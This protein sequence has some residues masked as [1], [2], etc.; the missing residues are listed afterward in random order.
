MLEL[1]KIFLIVRFFIQSSCNKSLKTKISC[2]FLCYFCLTH[3]RLECSRIRKTTLF[4]T[5]HRQAEEMQK[6]VSIELHEWSENMVN[7][8]NSNFLKVNSKFLLVTW[9]IWKQSVCSIIL[10]YSCTFYSLFLPFFVLE[11]FKFKYDRFFVRHSASISKFQWF[12]QL[13][14]WKWP[15]LTKNT[16]K[17]EKDP[18]L[19]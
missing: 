10:P 15:F 5:S 18:K 9:V 14:R 17:I 8:E 6:S 7:V 12:E 16:I 2:F 1:Q 19:S 11:I 13:F 3:P 4:L